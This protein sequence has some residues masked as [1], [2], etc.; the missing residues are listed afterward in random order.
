MRFL[1]DMN[2]APCW[3]PYLIAAGHECLHWSR[4]GPCDAPDDAICE[5]ARAQGWVLITNDLD[6]PQI[7]AYTREAKPSVILLRGEPLT[8]E[9]R[10]QAL[11]NA[12]AESEAELHSGGLLTIDWSDR[13]R[14]RLLP[15]R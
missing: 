15:L 8:P 14:A 6:F 4:L 12:I 5:F 10:G 2:L 1:I 3:V 7:L 13:V 11:L 9:L